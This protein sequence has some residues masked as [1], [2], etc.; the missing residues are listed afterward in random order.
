MSVLWYSI[1]DWSIG[2]GSLPVLVSCRLVGMCSIPAMVTRVRTD[3]YG[4]SILW[5]PVCVSGQYVRG[6]VHTMVTSMCIYLVSM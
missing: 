5:L 2:K 4:K 6:L 3:Q 1:D